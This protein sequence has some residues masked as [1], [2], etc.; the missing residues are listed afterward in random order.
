MDHLLK[1]SSFKDNRV[2]GVWKTKTIDKL[3]FQVK[4]LE[5]FFLRPH[6]YSLYK[7]T[8]IPFL[9]LSWRTHQFA[10]Y[11]TSDSFF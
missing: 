3:Y 8:K 4:D 2:D 9:L 6:N 7:M 5:F 11:I 1:M 10:R